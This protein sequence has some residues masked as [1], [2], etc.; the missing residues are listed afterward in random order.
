MFGC[1]NAQTF[2]NREIIGKKFLLLILLHNHLSQSIER[3]SDHLDH[4]TFECLDV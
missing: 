2:E 3:S 4:K 1:L